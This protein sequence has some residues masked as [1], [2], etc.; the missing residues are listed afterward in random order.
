MISFNCYDPDARRDRRLCGHRQALPDRRV[1][2]SRRRFRAAQYQR[3]RTGGGDASRARRLVPALRHLGPAKADACRLSL[4]RACRSAGRGAL[5]WREFKFRHG[6]DYR[7]CVR[8]TYSRDDI[9]QCQG[10]RIC[11]PPRRRSRDRQQ[12]NGND[13]SDQD[14][15]HRRDQHVVWAEH[16]A[17]YL[18]QR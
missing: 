14:R 11:T 10:R 13:Q 12:G 16:A 3:R 2:L 17:R 6:N 8:R 7:R 1:L 15:L 5:R 18:Q 9:G 4:V